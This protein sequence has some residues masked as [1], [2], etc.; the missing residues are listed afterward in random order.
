M[1]K[2]PILVVDDASYNR[3]LAPA[4]VALGYRVVSARSGAEGLREF[5]SV[6]PAWII[7][8]AGMPDVSEMMEAIRLRDDTIPFLVT[9]GDG[10]NSAMAAFRDRADEFILL[11]ADALMLE[12]V[13]RR[14]EN[15]VRLQRRI[16]SLSENLESRAKDSVRSIIETE[17]FLAVRQIV[18]KCRRSSVKWPAT[19]RGACVISMIC[20]ILSPS[21]AGI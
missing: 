8:S 16:R 17:R 2:Q 12:T 18:E 13:L 1:L 7:V 9:T 14:M 5:K 11:P 15:A 6:R 3:T 4:L 20:L 10:L 21:M 19:L